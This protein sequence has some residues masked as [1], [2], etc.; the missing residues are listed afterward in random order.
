MCWL[1]QY[2]QGICNYPL[3]CVILW[4]CLNIK[5]FSSLCKLF[6]V[7]CNWVA[8]FPICLESYFF[9]WV[10]QIKFFTTAAI[11]EMFPLG[12]AVETLFRH[13]S[14]SNTHAHTKEMGWKGGRPVRLPVVSY[15]ET[16]GLCRVCARVVRAHFCMSAHAMHSSVNA[17][18][19]MLTSV[20]TSD[21]FVCVCADNLIG[22]CCRTLTVLVF[23]RAQ[24]ASSCHRIST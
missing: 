15:M 5:L 19:Y 11:L 3:E 1:L 7:I 6:S 20:C 13:L 21:Q 12:K 23:E 14:L 17:D 24:L 10:K 18:V 9:Q 22:S 2:K 8:I 16:A 4:K